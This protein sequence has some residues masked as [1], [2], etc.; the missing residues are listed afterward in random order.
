VDGP[1]APPANGEDSANGAPSREVSGARFERRNF[2]TG[3]HRRVSPSR[4]SPNS[5]ARGTA[6]EA[7]PETSCFDAGV[8]CAFAA[9]ATERD[10]ALA[11]PDDAAGLEQIAACTGPTQIVEYRAAVRPPAFATPRGRGIAGTARGDAQER[12]GLIDGHG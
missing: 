9:A 12:A 4:P 3:L 8:D 2:L 1:G 6:A 10:P 5:T 11:V 7:A